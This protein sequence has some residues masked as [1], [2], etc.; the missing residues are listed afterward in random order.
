MTG[1]I[2]TAMLGRVSH[3]VLAWA[4]FSFCRLGL[5][6]IVYLIRAARSIKITYRPSKKGMIKT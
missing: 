1:V 4:A 3:I 5:I 6:I 2:G